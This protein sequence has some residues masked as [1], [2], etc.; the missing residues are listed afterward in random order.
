MGS[1]KTKR[2]YLESNRGLDYDMNILTDKNP[3]EDDFKGKENY[4]GPYYTTICNMP[5]I[6][7]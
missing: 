2:F 6:I 7:I 3:Q 4:F 5:K 1:K